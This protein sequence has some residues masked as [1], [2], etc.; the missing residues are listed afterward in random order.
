MEDRVKNLFKRSFWHRFA[1]LAKRIYTVMR[2]AATM[3]S[4]AVACFN[5]WQF[6]MWLLDQH[7]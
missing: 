5:A 3:I 4:V 6:L 7:S 1:S 2:Q